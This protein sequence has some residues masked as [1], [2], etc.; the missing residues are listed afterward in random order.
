M[1]HFDPAGLRRSRM[2]RH[3]SKLACLVL[4]LASV[5]AYPQ[6]PEHHAHSDLEFASSDSQLVDSFRWAKQEALSYVSDGDP[7]GPWYEAAL[8]GRH[9]FCM[10]D[11]AHQADGAQALG[12]ARYNH[13][14]LRRFA[15]NISASRDWCS[16]WE[17]D[18]LNRPAPVDYKSDAVFWYNLPANFDVLDACYR[19]YLWT[20]DRSYIDDP[21]FLNFYDRTIKNYTAHWNL[22]P[23]RV[24][25]RTSDIQTPPFF[26]GDPTYEES[27]T[28]NLVGVDLLA[29]QYAANRDYAAIQAIRGNDGAAES[30]LKTAA[31]IKSLINTEWWN[32]AQGYFY[33]FF[34]KQHQ[35]TGRAGADL[36]YRDAAD[37]GLKTASALRTLLTTNSTEPT[38]AVEAKSHYAEI[39]YRYGDPDAAYAEIM[40]LTRAGRERRD[41]PEVSYSVIGAMVTGLMGIRVEP[42][43]SLPEII[44]GKRFDTVIE[45][46]PQLTAKTS[47]AEIRN[48]PVQGHVISV[49][50][51]GNR[52]TT[53]TNKGNSPLEW[54]AAFAG[55]YEAL[56]SDGRQLKAHT[57]LHHFGHAITWAELT[58]PAGST[59]EVK[60]SK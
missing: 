42:T 31:Q 15:E 60:A 50:H 32:P 2:R 35:F 28:D 48:L 9:A 22:S 56:V 11:T 29:T 20:G 17:I 27:S 49:R 30:A 19:M 47:W 43:S 5:A 25:K 41:Y 18:R 36:L 58:V 46:L 34:N 37:D 6:Q 40:D 38:T 13:N 23:D 12:L 53:L 39:L 24:M 3:Q 44:S 45:T 26:R 4:L 59:V 16:Y 57:E 14:M 54:R 10:R 52:S 8:P 1:M 55:T 21:V 51:D 7:V 33:A